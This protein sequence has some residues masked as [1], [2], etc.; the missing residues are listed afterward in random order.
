V[1]GLLAVLCTAFLAALAR[2]AAAQS[3]EIAGS[4]GRPGAGLAVQSLTVRAT[5]EE[6]T[7]L[8]DLEQVFRNSTDQ[9]RE[10][11]WTIRLPDDAVVHTFSMWMAGKE[12]QGRVLEARKAREVYDSIVRGRRDPALLEE[13]G[14]R[15]FRVSV[16][17]IPAQD[18]VKIRLRYAHILPDDLGL[19]T[20]RIPLPTTQ[21]EVA[22]LDVTADVAVAAGIGA[23]DVP[24]PGG[25]TI[26]VTEGRASVRWSRERFR[27]TEPFTLRYAPKPAGF[28]LS[29]L[30]HRAADDPQGAFLVRL[31]P[32]LD[33]APELPRD[34]VFVVDRSGS[35]EGRKIEQARAA[36]RHGLGTL[37]TADRFAVVTFAS[38]VTTRGLRDAT[39]ANVTDA[40]AS[41]NEIDA[42]GGTNI[43]GALDAA[44]ALRDGTP[45]RLFVVVLLTDGDPTFGESRPDAILANWRERSQ[46]AVTPAAA[47]ATAPA[48]P[49]AVPVAPAAPA[50]GGA[51]VRLFA[52]GV[53]DDVKDFLL[54]RLARGSRGAAEYVRDEEAL[55]TKLSAL[56]E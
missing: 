48:Q 16:F 41:V 37:R 28:G 6:G 10:G 13:I 4:E 50:P 7:A 33:A 52:L 40:R 42:S 22:V 34:V 46:R 26:A 35:M 18:T 45:G 24:S 5:V 8:V 14:W 9:V 12:K 1:I 11:V 39:A 27:P 43:D 44:L 38:D 36:L 55:E 3:L 2:P 51:K 49:G 56:F 20:L 30:A 32:R 23:C 54:T 31:V 25:A 15:T 21:G 47:A 17:P 53:G 29:L 19:S